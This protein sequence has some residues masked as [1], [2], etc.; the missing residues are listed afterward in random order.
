MGKFDELTKYIPL[1][2]DDSFGDWIIDKENDGSPE[3]PIRM[4]FVH[5][6]EIVSQFHHDLY[7]FC[8]AHPEYEH[9]LYQATLEA[10]G[11]KWGQKPMEGADV[12]DKDAKCVIALL[13]G[14]TR[15]ERFCDGAM[16]AFFHKGC[17]L[18]WLE[19]L[20]EIDDQKLDLTEKSRGQKK[21]LIG[22]LK[23]TMEKPKEYLQKLDEDYKK[24][25]GSGLIGYQVAKTE[26]SQS[27]QSDQG[28]Q[29]QDLTKEFMDRMIPVAEMSEKLT[30]EVASFLTDWQPK[31]KEDLTDLRLGR[32][33]SVDHS[34]IY[35]IDVNGMWALLRSCSD[36][37]RDQ[38]NASAQA[39]QT[40]V[41]HMHTV[42]T[43][44][45]DIVDMICKENGIVDS[46]S[47][48]SALE[49][50]AVQNDNL[51]FVRRQLDEFVDEEYD[52]GED[53]D[54]L[55]DNDEISLWDV[56]SFCS[57]YNFVK[58]IFPYY[59]SAAKP[60]NPERVME[61]MRYVLSALDD[62]AEGKGVKEFSFSFVQRESDEML[63][64]TI[65]DD[66]ESVVSATEGGSVYTSGVGS[67]SFTNWMWTLWGSGHEDGQ[68]WLDTERV[69]EMINLGAKLSI[70]TPEEFSIEA[71]EAETDEQDAYEPDADDA[72]NKSGMMKYCVVGNIVKEHLDENGITRYG[73]TAFPGGRKVYISRRL[74]KN[75]VVVMGLN[76]YKSRYAFETV[77][78]EWI[79]NIR[80]SKTFSPKVLDLMQNTTESPDM[81]WRYKE[82][83]RVGATEYADILNRIKAGDNDAFEKYTKE[84][85]TRFY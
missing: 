32:R 78:L 3:H 62:F 21:G 69:T 16:L 68:L 29:K 7:E 2:K 4:P 14:M 40:V 67:D 46:R 75:G 71:D 6:S 74:W 28:E 82:E 73:T 63:Y 61:Y 49:A 81:W 24:I 65:S 51:D 72:K 31:S 66:G 30:Q 23:E 17:V 1:I 59:V 48:Y 19:R 64:I 38:Y 84:V 33:F 25:P 27:R 47:I 35:N 9:T 52:E 36:E 18:R 55:P 76:R 15:A 41:D 53:D 13:M 22:S 83:D 20:K 34:D 5:Y 11:L 70:E 8:E 37:E 44:R 26:I 43:I 58:D 39:I 45:D 12:S 10:N 57:L 50:L 85:M 54:E 79:E 80:F 60:E 56:E 42:C 77:P